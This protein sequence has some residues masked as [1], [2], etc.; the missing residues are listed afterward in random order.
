MKDQ[1]QKRMES[2]GYCELTEEEMISVRGGDKFFYWIGYY[3]GK[4]VR[5]GAEEN[6]IGMTAYDVAL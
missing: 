1:K 5:A 6:S 3:L 2:V 4:L